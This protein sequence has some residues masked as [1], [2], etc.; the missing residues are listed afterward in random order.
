MDGIDP[1][2]L[3]AKMGDNRDGYCNGFNNPL[4]MQDLTK[5]LF[6]KFS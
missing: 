3:L 5:E 1:N 4:N 6:K 2:L